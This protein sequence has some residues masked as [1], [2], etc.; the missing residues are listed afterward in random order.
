MV[1]FNAVQPMT[2]R[3]GCVVQPI[4]E[5]SQKKKL[6]T[7]KKWIFFDAL[8]VLLDDDKTTLPQHVPEL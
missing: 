6:K 5:T 7:K 1:F 4:K 3:S 8:S 2:P